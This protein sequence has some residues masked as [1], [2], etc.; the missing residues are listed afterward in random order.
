[1]QAIDKSSFHFILNRD[2]TTRSDSDLRS[3]MQE[4]RLPGIQPSLDHYWEFNHGPLY[5]EGHGFNGCIK[6]F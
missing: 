2:V 6:R 4:C 3:D 5:T 1:M